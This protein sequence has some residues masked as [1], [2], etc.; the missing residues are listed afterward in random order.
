MKKKMNADKG[1]EK[2]Q[3]DLEECEQRPDKYESRYK[4]G[5]PG[6]TVKK[7]EDY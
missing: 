4:H 6:R 3:D 5:G 1:A 7:K 2:I